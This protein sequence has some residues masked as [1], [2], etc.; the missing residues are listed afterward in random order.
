[1][2]TQSISVCIFLLWGCMLVICGHLCFLLEDSE[3]SVNGN[4]DIEEL[5]NFRVTLCL[6]VLCFF[7][8]FLFFSPHYLLLAN[9][10]HFEM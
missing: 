10:H 5:L 7:V 9:F 1:M 3:A 4:L 8:F 6:F 2:D